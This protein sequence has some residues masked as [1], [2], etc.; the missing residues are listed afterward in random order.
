MD[1]TRPTYERAILLNRLVSR[2]VCRARAE[3]KV[4]THSAEELI[5]ILNARRIDGRAVEFIDA[6]DENDE[7]KRLL[8]MATHDCLRLT[9]IQHLNDGPARYVFMLLE[10]IDASAREFPVFDVS[11]HSGR[12]L[13][14]NES[15]RGVGSVHLAIRLPNEGAY[16]DGAYRC[17]L[18]VSPRFSR[19]VIERFLCKQ[20]RRSCGHFEYTVETSKLG[21]RPK[22]KNYKYWPRLEL[23]ADI[24][25]SISARSQ[26]L[27]LS[28][29]VFTKRNEKQQAAAA[30]DITHDDLLADV[31]IRISA[32]QAPDDPEER[33][34][35]IE[36][37]R[38]WYQTRGYSSKLFYR[39]PAGAKGLAG[40]VRHDEAA[41]ADFLLCPREHIVI[42]G[43]PKPWHSAGDQNMMDAL[44]KLLDRDEL[45]EPNA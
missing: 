4:P 37:V 7:D 36:K 18:E 32:K 1:V 28:Q 3:I 14:G 30:T 39:A 23:M 13:K 34:R 5:A 2:S 35:W 22:P 38:D 15:E 17:C 21:R 16:D 25:T 43:D 19:A 26:G 31:E 45:W 42:E 24:S 6:I 44:R 41:A 33:G 11:T 10:Y 40:K 12:E 29:M 27:K 9:D 8:H 20:L